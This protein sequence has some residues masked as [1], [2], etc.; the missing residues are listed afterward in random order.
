MVEVKTVT[1]V[2]LG[3]DPE[4]PCDGSLGQ[5]LLTPRMYRDEGISLCYAFSKH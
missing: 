3:R 4:K 1:I 2:G 5:I